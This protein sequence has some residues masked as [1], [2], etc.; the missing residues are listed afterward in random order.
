MDGVLTVLEMTVAG[1]LRCSAQATALIPVLL[2]ILWL[3][4]KRMS[5][6]G[7]WCLWWIVAGR[8]LL[9]WSPGAPFSLFEWVDV[10]GWARAGIFHDGSTVSAADPVGASRTPAIGTET[11][12]P[13]EPGS[14]VGRRYRRPPS[15][16]RHRAA[17]GK[18]CPFSAVSGRWGS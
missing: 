11:A 10:R 6:A 9:P 1:V 13:A 4:G 2:L 18:P 7:R 14:V 3:V 15:R 8:L 5:A 17:R 16:R 12:K